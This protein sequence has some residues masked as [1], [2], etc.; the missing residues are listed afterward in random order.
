MK[1]KVRVLLNDTS[2]FTSYT[3]GD[4]LLDGPVFAV[5]ANS[6]TDVPELAWEIGNKEGPNADAYDRHFQSVSVGDVILITGG[7]LVGFGAMFACD[8]IGW[9][10]LI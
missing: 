7:D 6:L 1:Y 4:T 3:P 8:M 10:R 5:E 9:K 2:G